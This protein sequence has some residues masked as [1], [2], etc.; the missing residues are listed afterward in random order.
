VRRRSRFTLVELL[1]TITIIAVLT[2]MLMPAVAKSKGVAKSTQCQGNLKQLGVATNSYINDYGFYPAAWTSSGTPGWRWVD[3][4]K[5][6]L[7]NNI[8]VFAC[9]S[10]S[11]RK[12]FAND[13][14][15]KLVLSYGI[16]CTN[17]AQDKTYYFWYPVK[18]QSV[19]S[20]SRIIL[21]ADSL[22]SINASAQNARYYFGSGTNSP[23][24]YI[25]N[26]HQNKF[27]AVFCDGHTEF[28]GEDVK[29]DV[30]FWN[31]SL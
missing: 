28:H 13:P 4:V 31:A 23:V 5:P 2:G 1:I 10:D 3:E 14:E 17:F 30:Q 20:S 22:P 24:P 19:K 18:V 8:E 7:N 15:Q 11:S 6:H 26:R 21:Y 9:P 25:E 16:N 29:Y 27:C 12:A